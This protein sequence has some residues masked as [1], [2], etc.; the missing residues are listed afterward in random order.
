MTHIMSLGNGKFSDSE[1]L[2]WDTRRSLKQSKAFAEDQRKFQLLFNFKQW[3]SFTHFASLLFLASV[4]S[5]KEKK[6]STNILLLNQIPGT[7][8]DRQSN[9]STTI[10]G[11]WGT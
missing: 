8:I 11:L 4:H 1:F 3:H 7:K 6:K 9:P 2:Q 5:K 10:L